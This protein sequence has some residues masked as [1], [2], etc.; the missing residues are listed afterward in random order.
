MHAITCE[1]LEEG[2]G[3]PGAISCYVDAENCPWVISTLNTETT[4][5]S[6]TCTTLKQGIQKTSFT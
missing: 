4:L 2:V 5:L 6:L 1:H 3:S